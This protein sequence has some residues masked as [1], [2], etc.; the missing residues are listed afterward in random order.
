MRINCDNPA[1]VVRA[2]RARAYLN[3]VE[4]RACIMADE[5]AGM[6]ERWETDADG[7][8]MAFG[9]KPRRIRERGSVRIEFF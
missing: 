2:R 4:V 6:I 1:D 8:V 9:G 3:D 7:R 5:E